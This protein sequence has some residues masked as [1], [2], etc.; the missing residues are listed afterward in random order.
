[1]RILHT[2]DS[3]GIYGAETVLLNLA[4]EQ[5]R[6][7]ERPVLLSIGSPH[8]AEK[9]IEAEARRRGIECIPLRMRDGLNFSGAAQM[10]RIAEAQR[11]DVIHSHG[12]KSNILLGLAPRRSRRLPV[13]TTL[14]GWT[15]KRAWS[16]LGLYRLLDQLMLPRL[17]GVVVVNE[18]MLRLRALTR[19]RHPARAIANGVTSENFAPGRGDDTLTKNIAGLRQS[20]STLLGVVGRLSPEKNVACLVEA[21]HQL[22][23]SHAGVGLVIF[24][25]GPERETIERTIAQLGMSRRVLLSG[26]VANARQ[27]LAS[28]DVLVIPS[29]TEGLPMILL[30][31]MAACV[32]VI[33][34]RVGD[35]PAVLGE[36]GVLVEPG[37]SK[38]LAAA[39]A[40]TV[41]ELPKHRALAAQGADRIA[42]HYSASAMADRYSE[43]YR[44]VAARQP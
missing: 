41:D 29:L 37:D 7:G 30:E 5:Q 42:A 35:I 26:Y 6:R 27:Y 24:G 44:S 4:T 9:A 1:M 28:L 43:V 11:V 31:A 33:A 32:P 39:I 38:A 40:A 12:Y 18:Q 22:A 17:D 20:H 3:L 16:K 34:T 13:I 8:A 21:L 19:L 2:I 14:H 36:L 15:A 23:A 10:L 25:D